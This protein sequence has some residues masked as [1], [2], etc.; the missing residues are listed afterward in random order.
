M[1]G[2]LYLRFT[3]RLKGVFSSDKDIVKNNC[4]KILQNKTK[5]NSMCHLEAMYMHGILF[6]LNPKDLL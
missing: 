4:N 5:H 1:N 2:Y 6:L 3:W